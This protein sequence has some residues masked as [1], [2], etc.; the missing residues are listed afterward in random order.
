M[1]N[2]SLSIVFVLGFLTLSGCNRPDIVQLTRCTIL[3]N[4]CVCTDSMGNT[5]FP[6]D[7][8]VGYDA[9]SLEDS[10]KL[11]NFILERERRLI[12]CEMGGKRGVQ[13]NVNLLGPD[14]EEARYE[15]DTR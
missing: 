14:Q 4:G 12:E 2:V 6:A 11:T 13:F 7:K 8:C 3:E 10:N 15:E 5:S 1:K 9:L